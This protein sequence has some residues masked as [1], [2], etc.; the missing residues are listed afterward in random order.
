MQIVE[1]SIYYIPPSTFYFL[2]KIMNKIIKSL[3]VIAFVAAIAVGA[4]S[5]YF[6]D[7]EKAVGNTITAG[8]IDIKLNGNET[9][10]TPYVV[11]DVKPGETGYMNIDVKNVGTNP[12]KVSKNL[13]S[14]VPTTGVDTYSCTVADN[15]II[16][17]SSEPECEAAKTNPNHVDLNDLRT[18]ILY[19]LSVKVY[20]MGNDTTP[21]QW[22]TIYTG[23]AGQTLDT[24][25]PSEQSYVALG[26]IPVG[27]HMVV[28]QSYHFDYN[29]GNEYQGDVLSFDITIK[30]EQ[31][32]GQDGMA[33]VVLENKTYSAGQWNIVQNDQISGTLSYKTQG[34]LFDYSFTGKAPLVSH[35]YVLAVGY[36][37]STDV[38]TQIGTGMTDVNGNITIT[39]TFNT[40]TLT[41]AKV[42]LVPTENWSG[43][44]MNW[45]GGTGWPS[46]VPNFL[47]ETGLINYTKN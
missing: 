6:S 15:I 5:A 34:P 21:V 40:N 19:D 7:E 43:S 25:Y 41:N 28:T 11:A 33:S 31:L 18:Q 10:V 17:V 22:Q 2:S 38:D 35:A 44:A 23:A 13:S 20:A 30:G 32:T 46:V 26:T 47:W 27:G 45:A 14:F 3:A 24:I 29:A 37:V 12:V 1:N 4:T 16:G 36:N 39:G 42:W 8:T 9:V